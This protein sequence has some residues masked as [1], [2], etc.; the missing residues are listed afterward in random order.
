M[1]LTL[2]PARRYD[3]EIIDGEGQ[4]PAEI[5]AALDDIRRVNRYLGGASGILAPIESLAARRGW[6]R[7]SVLDVGTGSADIPAALLGL[8]R[9][10]GWEVRVAGVDMHAEIARIA[11]RRVPIPLLR[12]DG[13]RLPFRDG[14]YDVVIA[15][16]FL[17]HF[18]DSEASLMVRELCRVARAALL[19]NDLRRHAV[20]FLAIRLL[21]RLAGASPMFR[22]D[23][24]LSV[25][26]GFT[27]EEL[28]RIA[29]RADLEGA[30]RVERRF[31]YRLLLTVEKEH[32]A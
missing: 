31:P 20:P 17:H 16:L 1:P 9:R 22:N 6:R 4:D 30:V 8:A 28:T 13:F 5:E 26:R 11:S 10:R 32:T 19:I 14:T 12:A 15:S 2:V 7:F 3:P 18:D 21:G 29:A 27:P 25:L 24:P 23:A